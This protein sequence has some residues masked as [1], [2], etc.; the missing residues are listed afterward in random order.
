[1]FAYLWFPEEY[2]EP[3]ISREEQAYSNFK[4]H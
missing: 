3:V 2:T 4:G 1:M